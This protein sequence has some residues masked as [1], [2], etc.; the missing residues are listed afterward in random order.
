[1]LQDGEREMHNPHLAINAD[2]YLGLGAY[3]HVDEVEKDKAKRSCCMSMKTGKLYD[4]DDLLLMTP[5]KLRG[6]DF[7][8]NVG[9]VTTR[10]NDHRLINDG[11]GNMIPDV[12][13][14]C[15]ALHDLPADHPCLVYI[16]CRG[17]DAVALEQQ[18]GCCYCEEETPE[19][20]ST[21]VYYKRHEAGWRATPQGRL[22]FQVVLDGVRWGWQARMLDITQ[23]NTRMVYHP[24]KRQWDVVSVNGVYNAPYT[25]SFKPAKYLNA[26]GSERTRMLM[27]YD[28]AVAWSLR[29]GKRTCILVEGPLD[30]ARCGAPAIAILGKFLSAN[31]ASKLKTRFNKFVLIPDTDTA[32]QQGLDSMKRVLGDCD[33]DVVRL[34]HGYKDIGELSRERAVNLINQYLYE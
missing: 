17:Y 7:S 29:E 2:M 22:I 13:G 27:G 15:I 18:F 21:G 34:P 12:P 31:Q 14:R 33:I 23:N 32:G 9:R 19:N 30:A 5:I 1:M 3:T 16:A 10:K 28:A 26:P 8:I 25:E 6:L 4:V 24:Y 11:K 20:R